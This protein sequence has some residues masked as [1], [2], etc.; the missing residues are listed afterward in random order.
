MQS[1]P[2]AA[3]L[4]LGAGSVLAARVAGEGSGEGWLG[5]GSFAPTAPPR[6][7][8]RWFLWSQPVEVKIERA[9][10]AQKQRDCITMPT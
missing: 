5:G 1:P 6:R 3:G 7:S 2:A 9:I 10:K 4:L 8:S